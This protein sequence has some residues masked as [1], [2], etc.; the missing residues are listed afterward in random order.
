MVFEF[1]NICVYA[2]SYKSILILLDDVKYVI[3]N[4]DVLRKIYKKI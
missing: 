1:Q 3:F 4:D 2:V